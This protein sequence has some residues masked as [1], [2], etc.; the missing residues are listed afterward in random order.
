MKRS[1]GRAAGAAVA[2]LLLTL[3]GC[4]YYNTLY[5]AKSRFGEASDMPRDREGTVSRRAVTAYDDVIL[6]CRKMIAT[7]PDSRH[8]DDALLLMA[9]SYDASD[10]FEECVGVIDTLEAE[11]PKSDLLPKALALKGGAL[12]RWEHYDEAVEVLEK[13]LEKNKPTASV[14]YDLSTSLMSLDRSDDAVEY[15]AILEQKFPKSD[16]TMDAR[17]ATA[18]ILADKGQYEESLGVYERLNAQ[19][20]PE[21]VRYRVWMGYVGVELELKR[22]AEALSTIESLQGLLLSVEQMPPVLLKKADALAGADSTNAAIATYSDITTR[23]SRG[24]Y[25]AEAHYRLGHIYEK[26]D[27]LE[28]AKSH[29][30]SVPTAYANSQFARESIKEGNNI[31]QLIRLQ[32]SEGDENPEAK[33]QREFSLAELQLFQFANTDRAIE[34][35]RKLLDDY[36]NSD[37]A[38]KAAYAPIHRKPGIPTG[39]C[40]NATPTR[41]KH[42]T[43]GSSSRR[44]VRCPRATIPSC[45]W[46]PPSSRTPREGRSRRRT[47]P[48]KRS[49]RRTPPRRSSLR[50]TRP[51]R[52]SFRRTRPRGPLLRRTPRRKPAPRRTPPEERESSRLAIHTR[53]RQ[54]LRGP[55]HRQHPT[56]PAVF[57]AADRPPG[58]HARGRGGA[59][60][61]GLGAGD[62][63]LLPAP[64][65]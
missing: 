22:Y 41:S 53:E 47:P 60:R 13:W 5:N 35:Y 33:A 39:S 44:W 3:A 18:E 4:A 62:R 54:P 43:P 38:P 64:S 49:F 57:P 12:A 17:I 42:D 10:R 58:G 26:M 15:L 36:P 31:A 6:K 52:S 24:E 63:T 27:S 28:T 30:E 32:Q 1:V 59:L 16:E 2:V 19:R 37:F 51:R 40:A 23:F 55:R 20:L 34:A 50:R 21:T 61:P 9:R 65:L 11:H 45:R 46:E 29:F 48:G 7:W 25:A 8:V 14:L 56:E